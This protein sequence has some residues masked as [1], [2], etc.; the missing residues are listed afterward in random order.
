MNRLKVEKLALYKIRA[1]QLDAY[2]DLYDLYYKQIYRYIYFKVPTKERAED[3]T[4][5]TFLKCWEYI[6]KHENAVKNFQAFIYQVSR[7]L[8]ADFYK[9]PKENQ[10]PIFDEKDE[11]IQIEDTDFTQNLEL[12]SDWQIL[13]KSLRVLGKVNGK[14]QEAVLLKHIEGFSINE[15]A[16]L[17]NESKSN[18][19]VLI[20]RGMEKLKELAN[21]GT[22]EE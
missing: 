13:E 19:K 4:S 1:G 15:I 14:W 5:D 6:N 12:L 9:K 22:K 16:N 10:L 8:I 7:N 3:L 20:H 11:A 17:L 18:V 21:K 2:A